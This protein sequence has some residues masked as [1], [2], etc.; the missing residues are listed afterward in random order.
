MS[1]AQIQKYKYKIHNY[2]NTTY[3]ELPEIPNILYILNSSEAAILRRDF[4]ILKNSNLKWGHKYFWQHR[5]ILYKN[6][7]KYKWKDKNTF[8]QHWHKYKWKDKKYFYWNWHKYKWKENLHKI[9]EGGKPDIWIF[10]PAFLHHL[11][12]AW[13]HLKNFTYQIWNDKCQMSNVKY[14]ISNVD[15]V[16]LLSE[17]TSEVPPVIFQ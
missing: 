17:R 12:K 6:W 14:Q 2:T 11:G 4:L 1:H 15:K 13:Q 9:P 10:M 8:Y 16:K 3:D 5:Q 7:H